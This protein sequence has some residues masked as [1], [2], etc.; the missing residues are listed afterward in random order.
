V[1]P[2]I[3]QA[4][5]LL[6]DTRVL[7]VDKSAHN[8]SLEL[9]PKAVS[10]FGNMSP[11]GSLRVGDSAAQLN[12]MLGGSQFLLYRLQSAACGENIWSATVDLVKFGRLDLA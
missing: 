10:W 1:R 11:L 9:S 3:P 4:K 6:G 7:A 2:D 5:G 12:S 8:K